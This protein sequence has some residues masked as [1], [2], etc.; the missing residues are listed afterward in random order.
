MRRTVISFLAAATIAS[1]API[2]KANTGD[3]YK[4][5]TVSLIISTGSGGGYDTTARIVA[6][7]LPKYLPGA[8]SIVPK[9]MPGAGNVLAA[10]YMYNLAPRDGL[11]LATLAQTVFLLQPLGGQ[12]VKFD[13]SKFYYLGSA[14]VDNSTIYVWHTAGIRS[15][16]D[17]TQKEVLFG[18]TGVGSG[19]T[20]YP[21]LM[22]N[23]LGTKIRI[24][25]GYKT[26]QD[27]DLAMERGEVQGRAGNNFQSLK[28]NRSDWLTGKKLVFMAQV[29]LQR[30]SEYPDLPLLTEF[31]RTEEQRQ[32]IA[33]FS[34][35]IAIG[36]PFLTTPDVPADRASALRDAFAKVMADPDFIAEAQKASLDIKPVS[37]E[38]LT[39][40]VDDL[41]AT[42]PAVV[43][44]AKAV[45]DESAIATGK[46]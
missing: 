42:P 25:A 33:M 23:L 27:I 28:A 43:A 8:P 9:N 46:K 17:A 12:G 29:G 22:N 40:I 37:G 32:I 7:Y 45:S 14:S 26:S 5:K 39:K 4:D 13:A 41:I 15:I 31:A 18:A 20:V 34:A 44:R 3:F 6:R 30:D 35:P 11:T 38:R 24:I 1:S 2:A 16:E 10:N 19:S 21:L 36:R